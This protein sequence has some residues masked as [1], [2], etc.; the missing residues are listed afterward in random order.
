MRNSAGRATGTLKEDMSF[1]FWS[2]KQIQ[3]KMMFRLWYLKQ[4]L[5]GERE[6]RLVHSLSDPKLVTLDVGS[7]RGLYAV[8]AL[9]YS[10]SVLAFEPQPYFASFLRKYLPPK[11]EVHECAVSDV[12]GSATLQVP[13]D[14]RF[15]AEARLSTQVDTGTGEVGNFVPV[16]VPTLRLDD[17]IR[18][19]VG[20]MKIDVEGHELAVLNGATAIID[21]YRPNIIIEI[22]NRHRDGAVA[23]AFRWFEARQYHGFYLQGNALQRAEELS[24]EV[25]GPDVYNFIFL[26]AERPPTMRPSLFAA[27]SGVLQL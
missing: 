14:P 20:L 15:H 6:L 25:S 2:A 9:P 13:S 7:N 3:S 22:E 19:K 17:V 1:R 8:A 27:L 21:R 23:S 4:V 24:S 26:P 11:V 10:R 12:A 18:E 5:S 16:K